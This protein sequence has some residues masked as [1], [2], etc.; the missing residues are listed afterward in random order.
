MSLE[1]KQRRQ[2][3]DIKITVEWWEAVCILD[4]GLPLANQVAQ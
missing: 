1:K 2:V 3:G 4:K